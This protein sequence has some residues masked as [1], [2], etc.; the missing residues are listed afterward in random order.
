MATG[1]G[2]TTVMG[3]LAAWSILNKLNNRSDARFSDAVLGRVSQRDD[4]RSG[5]RNLNPVREEASIYRTR[6]LVPPHLMPLLSQGRVIVTN[7]HVF[8]PQRMDT[9][10]VSAK[11]VKAGK[12][13]ESRKASI[14][15]RRRQRRVAREI[16]YLSLKGD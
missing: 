9:G 14:S 16:R 7:W 8:Q 12:K 5:W 1:S 10:G 4:P 11:V 13:C 2:K 15:G 3:M 6:D